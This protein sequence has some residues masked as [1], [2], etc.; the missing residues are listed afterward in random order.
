MT[1][2]QIKTFL[3][4]HRAHMGVTREPRQMYSKLM[5]DAYMISVFLTRKHE[6]R[7]KE[8]RTLIKHRMRMLLFFMKHCPPIHLP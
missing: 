8:A 7:T 5:R 2:K 4:T 3:V 6:S 1:R